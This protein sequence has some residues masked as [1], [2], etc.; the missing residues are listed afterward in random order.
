MRYFFKNW[1]RVRYVHIFLKKVPNFE[2]VW[3]APATPRA[4]TVKSV[5]EVSYSW[6]GYIIGSVCNCV[7][8]RTAEET[9]N[10]T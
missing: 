5:Y 9:W 3:P 2:L 4:Q 8:S 1:Y 6:Y 7:C 10:F